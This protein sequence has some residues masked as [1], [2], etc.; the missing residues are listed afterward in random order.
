MK[1]TKKIVS[2][3]LGLLSAFSFKSSAA[4][5]FDIYDDEDDESTSIDSTSFIDSTSDNQ[6]S[7]SSSNKMLIPALVVVFLP[8]SGGLY[9][10]SL[11]K[12]PKKIPIEKWALDNCGDK[13]LNV[14]KN[15]EDAIYIKNGLE[16]KNKNEWILSADENTIKRV[17]TYYL[18]LKALLQLQFKKI[19]DID[20]VNSF[21]S[22]NEI[23]TSDIFSMYDENGLLVTLSSFLKGAAEVT[24]SQMG[25]SCLIAISTLRSLYELGNLKINQGRLISNDK[26]DQDFISKSFNLLNSFLRKNEQEYRKYGQ[27]VIKRIYSWIA[28]C[29]GVDLWKKLYPD[30]EYDEQEYLRLQKQLCIMLPLYGGAC[31]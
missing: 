8:L 13:L 10:K 18:F 4:V 1:K 2:T 12:S 6:K 3:I 19:F 28:Y 15:S 20:N 24:N 26:K 31:R 11:N 30:K 5:D 25:D 29:L 22:K 16:E 27:N 9:Y 17:F 23:D 7:T 14:F 21:E